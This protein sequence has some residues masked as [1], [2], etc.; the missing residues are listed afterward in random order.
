M[1]LTNTITVISDSERL[2]EQISSKL[3]LLRDLDKVINCKLTDAMN[4]LK[5]TPPNVIILHCD[6]NNPDA[7]KLVKE[8]RGV[9]IF[10]QTPILFLDDQ[11]GRET[12]I[13]AFDSG[14]TDIIKCP[15]YDH[16][17]LIRTI[18]CIQKEEMT[19]GNQAR[20]EFMKT[21]GIIQPDTGVYTQKYCE[22]FLKAE[23]NRIKRYKT[24]ACIMLISPD[25]KYP[26]YKNPK[27]FLEVINK[28][29]RANDTVAIKDV[30]EFYIFLPKTKLNGVYPIF[31]RINTNL[32]V[33]C[34]ANASVIEIKDEDFDTLKDFLAQA[35]K[36]AKEETNALIV[37]SSTHSKD[38]NAGINLAKQQLH[39]PQSKLPEEKT[40]QKT[41][42]EANEEKTSKL[43]KQA[44][45]QKCKV[46]FEPVFDK[47]QSYISSKIKDIKIKYR[48]AVEN[49]SFV[50]L[51]NDVRASL[52]IGYG[53]LYKVRID[54]LISK[55]NAKVSSNSIVFDFMQLNFQKLSQ[56]LEELYIN[57]KNCLKT[58]P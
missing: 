23:L 13:D 37:A 53:G 18:W 24:S 19:T 29:V 9:S 42:I 56:I 8:I 26:G 57:F 4:F 49:T 47:Y 34:G 45:R 54:T 50:M 21:L 6:K 28:S 22:E 43:H 51:K 10:A 35:L 38:P 31:E 33:D 46:V 55:N 1:G 5:V 17:L 7:I 36:K 41:V 30:D 16:E 58:S 14:V 2:V 15:I 3:V 52:S 20:E 48:A 25:S 12:I 11:C 39:E 32:G 44:Y 27:E 40:E